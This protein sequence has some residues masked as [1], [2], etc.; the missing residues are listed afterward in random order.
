MT[1]KISKQDK[2]DTINHFF[3]KKGLRCKTL[4]LKVIEDVI[5]KHN[6]DFDTEYE[7]MKKERAVREEEDKRQKEYEAEE[8]RLRSIRIEAQHAKEKQEYDNLH[9]IYKTICEKKY[10]V[11]AY[12]EELKEHS[13]RC[14]MN[15]R[16]LD[17][18]L[19]NGG[20][21]MFN[22]IDEDGH[23]VINCITVINSRSSSI[24]YIIYD[25]R[26]IEDLIQE[27]KQKIVIIKRKKV[28]KNGL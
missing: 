22:Y 3:F 5:V 17:D 20:N 8:Y 14:K 1:P 26:F 6:I 23:V 10:K 15:K 13:V 27:L 21:P 19:R 25:N 7:S 4:T 24:R 18:S 16:L 9:Q 11:E 28:V 12:M 2:M